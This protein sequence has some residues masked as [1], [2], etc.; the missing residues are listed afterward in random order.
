MA[1]RPTK[2][3]VTVSATA[4]TKTCYTT[5]I[6]NGYVHAIR[7]VKSTSG[8]L[9][10]TADLDIQGTTSGISVLTSLAV[11]SASFTKYPRVACVNSTNGAL[12][13]YD[14]IPI[15][16]ETLKISVSKTTAGANNGTFYIYMDG[17]PL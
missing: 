7:Y 15:H 3:T 10:S 16:E 14:R 6:L 8:P 2:Y 13:W 1:I 9:S 5:E 11:G 4:S 12:T 17:S